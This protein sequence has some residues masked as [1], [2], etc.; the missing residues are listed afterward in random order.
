MFKKALLL[1][2]M[3]ILTSCSNKQNTKQIDLN[4]AKTI[5]MSYY[6]NSTIAS[7]SFNDQD[8]IPNYSL[9]LT[10]DT[11]YYEIEVNAT[12]GSLTEHFREP[13]PAST[14]PTINQAKAKELALNLHPGEIT[15]FNLD[16]SELT[17]YYEITINDGT[18]EYELEINALTGEVTELEQK[19][20]SY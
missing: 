13:L 2:M 6:P 11:N 1:I 7:I 8:T 10:D 14:T 19:I 16:N 20:T 4:D 3:L 12:N 18:Y 17:P 15:E 9:T 5:A